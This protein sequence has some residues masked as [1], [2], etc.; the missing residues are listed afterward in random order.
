MSEEVNTMVA[1]SDPITEEMKNSRIRQGRFGAIIAEKSLKTIDSLLSEISHYKEQML[2]QR[3]E[4]DN[5]I[6]AKDR[7]VR[8]I[9]EYAN[10]DLIK[11]LLP[12]LD[13]IDSAMMNESDSKVAGLVR[14]QILKIL[15]QYGF[16]PIEAKGTKFDP[17]LHEA[18]SVTENGED[19]M[20][21]EEIQKG[22]KL[23]DDVIRTS[24]VI[25][26]KR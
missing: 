15:S 12:V 1:I 20:I 10:M 6:K 7:E 16:K 9:R 25:V 8:N 24:K 19:G 5:Y 3:A 22:Y 17:Y 4:I 2:R 23:K 11:G 18:I 14:G 26:G 21:V 13:S